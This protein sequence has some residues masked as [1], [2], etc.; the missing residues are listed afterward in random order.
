MCVC[1]CMGVCMRAC[2][3]A[4]ARAIMSLC[5]GYAMGNKNVYMMKTQ[6]ACLFF[7]EYKHTVGLLVL[8]DTRSHSGS[9]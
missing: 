7:L 2:V 3:R 1:S 9:L 4:C 8:S 5:A 6:K